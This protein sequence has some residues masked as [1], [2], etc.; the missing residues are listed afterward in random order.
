MQQ[1]AWPAPFLKDSIDSLQ[2][3]PLQG[4]IGMAQ[5][6]FDGKE[7]YRTIRPVIAGVEPTIYR[8]TKLPPDGQWSFST[9]ILYRFR[10]S[11]PHCQFPEGRR[12]S[13]SDEAIEGLKAYLRS[14]VM[15]SGEPA[16]GQSPEL[17]N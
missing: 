5:K 3:G 15:E 12:Y 7:A 6:A 2:L 13:S 1:A 4:P 10:G 17:V 8:D 14:Y 9:R 16:T 11:N